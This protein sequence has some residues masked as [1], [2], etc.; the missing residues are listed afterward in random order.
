MKLPALDK[1]AKTINRVRYYAAGIT[2]HAVPRE[3]YLQRCRQILGELEASPELEELMR[4]A[5]YYNRLPPCSVEPGTRLNAVDRAQ[6]R[7]Y[8]DLDEYLR[9]F[10]CR[11]KVDYLF[12]DVTWVPNTPSIVKS[13]PTGGENGNSVLLN[14]DK[15]RHFRL[16]ADDTPWEKKKPM[17]VWRGA[18]N[19]PLRMELLRRHH[20]SASAD[21]GHIGETKDGVQAKGF[22]SPQDQM[23]YRY[24]L[25]IEGFDVATNL[26][27]IMASRSVCVM[28][29]GRYETWF[30]E[31]GLIPDHHFVEVRPDFSDLEDKIA[32]LERNPQWAQDIVANANAYVASF[33]DRKTERKVSLLVLQ[34]YFEATG[35]LPPSAFSPL[36]FQQTRELQP[37]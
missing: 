24:I 28:P 1:T 33:C 30:M 4:R 26:K 19:N 34:K 14:L 5:N 35:Q 21:V 9:Y 27:W 31:G 12:G 10:P 22:L 37:A 8:F 13:R 6:S 36:F 25:S 32:E 3:W 2:R 17:A 11:L 7:Y 18:L 15:L 20:E 16:C 23:G 29:K